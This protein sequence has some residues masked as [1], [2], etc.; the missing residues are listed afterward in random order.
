MIRGLPPSSISP[1]ALGWFS[2]AVL[3]PAVVLDLQTLPA[4]SPQV[5]SQLERGARLS[6][7]RSPTR[8]LRTLKLRHD[9]VQG[10]LKFTRSV[11]RQARGHRAT[12][13]RCILKDLGALLMPAQKLQRLQNRLACTVTLKTDL[14][15]QPGKETTNLAVVIAQLLV[16]VV[17][18]SLKW[19]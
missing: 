4:S 18:V 5:A 12:G 17:V 16:V 1:T 11:C 6:S 7:K 15:Q 13:P 2:R 10:K 9:G 14:L 3:T 19:R 8:R